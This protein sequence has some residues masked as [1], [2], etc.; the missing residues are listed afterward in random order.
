MNLQDI[1]KDY[2]EKNAELQKVK[3][4]IDMRQRQIHRLEKKKERA[5]NKSHWTH[6]VNEIMKLVEEKTPHVTWDNGD[7]FVSGLRCQYY[8]FG[9]TNEGITVALCFTPGNDSNINFDTGEQRGNFHS[10]SIGA[11]NGF[12][13]VSKRLEDIQELLDVV[14]RSEQDERKRK[15]AKEEA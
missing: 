12:N 9:K 10:R 7:R 11:A 4:R 13:N 1:K 8:R 14:E 6:Q 2:Q 15:L 3:D 5:Q